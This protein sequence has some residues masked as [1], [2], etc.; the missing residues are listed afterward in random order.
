MSDAT[1]PPGLRGQNGARTFFRVLGP[2]VVIVALVLLVTA[3][4]DFFSAM[5]SFGDQPT[6][7]AMFFVGLP[8]LAVG[9]W[10]TQA[11]F[12]GAGARYAAGELAPV[13]KDTAGYL[14][15]GQ[16]IL[17]VGRAPS[18]PGAGPYCRQCGV[19]ND[20]DARFC[21]SCGTAFG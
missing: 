2:M 19:R 15:D 18:Q 6:K 5:S 12:M 8:L 20:A 3:G 7:F 21:D 9:G 4:M 1:P 14:S 17:G 10:L 11:G 16:G 13:V